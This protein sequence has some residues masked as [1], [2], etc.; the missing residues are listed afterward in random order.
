MLYFPIL[1][2]GTYLDTDAEYG[3]LTKSSAGYTLTTSSGIEDVFLA[4]GQFD[5]EQDPNGNRISLGYNG[6]NQLVTLTYSNP[7]DSSQPTQQLSLTYNAQGLVSQVADGTGDVWTYTYDSAGHLLSVTAPGPTTAGLTT[8]YTYDTGTNPET[9]NALLSISSPNGL[10]ENFT[11]SSATGRLT[12]TT[13]N[14]GTDAITYTYTYPDEAEVVATDNAGNKTTVWF[15]DLGRSAHFRTRWAECPATY[16][17]TTA[18]WW[19][20]PIQPAETTSTPTVPTA[21]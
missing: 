21:T 18:T 8:S 17:T 15:N 10:Q 11:Y 9:T 6:Q 20:T 5:Y 2:N 13:T 4:N 12:G 1:A 19:G 7:S 3:T 16:T 14:G